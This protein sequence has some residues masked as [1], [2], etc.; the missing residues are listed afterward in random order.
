METVGSQLLVHYRVIISCLCLLNR[1]EHPLS[2]YVGWFFSS[3]CQTDFFQRTTW[4]KLKLS[5][6]PIRTINTSFRRLGSLSAGW[7]RIMS[8]L[9]CGWLTERHSSLEKSTFSFC[10]ELYDPKRTIFT[11]VAFSRSHQLS[12][13]QYRYGLGNRLYEYSPF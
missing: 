9:A 7:S 13:S 11:L 1:D 6:L 2:T 5:S 4:L 10:M 3:R 8:L 12:G